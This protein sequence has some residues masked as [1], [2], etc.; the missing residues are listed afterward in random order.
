MGLAA[1]HRADN[2]VVRGASKA[3]VL[4]AKA[5]RIRK[6]TRKN[7]LFRGFRA[8]FEHGGEAPAIAHRKYEAASCEGG[9]ECP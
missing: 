3:G 6:M 2:E 9:G 1:E 5:S 7:G 8:A 4:G